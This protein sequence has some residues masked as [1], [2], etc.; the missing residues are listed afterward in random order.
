MVNY[1]SR[2]L[3]EVATIATQIDQ[4]QIEK[5]IDILIETRIANGRI[6]L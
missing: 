3:S 4:A 5:M 2:Y 1:T 6:F